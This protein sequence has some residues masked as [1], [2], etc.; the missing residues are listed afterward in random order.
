MRTEL[1]RGL[2]AIDV[3]GHPVKMTMRG[4]QS[5]PNILARIV[6]LILLGLCILFTV[7]MLIEPVE[8]VVTN[9][10]TKKTYACN[11]RRHLST[12]GVN[13]VNDGQ[14]FLIEDLQYERVNISETEVKNKPMENDNYWYLYPFS[15]YFNVAFRVRDKPVGNNQYPFFSVLFTDLQE[16]KIQHF[17]TVPCTNNMFHPDLQAEAGAMNISNYLCIHEPGDI[18]LRGNMYHEQLANF[19]ILL[20]DCLGSSCIDNPTY[21]DGAIVDLV[22]TQGYYSR[23]GNPPAKFRFIQEQIYIE[24]HQKIDKSFNVRWNVIGSI[25][26]IS[27]NQTFYSLT[28]K[29]EYYRT[30]DS[31]QRVEI[32]FE[33][34]SKYRSYGEEEVT[35]MSNS[36]SRNLET[37]FDEESN[38]KTSKKKM[39]VIYEIFYII[40][41]IGGLIN[42]LFL[43]FSIITKGIFDRYFTFQALNLSFDS[44]QKAKTKEP[45]KQSAKQPIQQE[46]PVIQDQ[47]EI[48]PTPEGR[49]PNSEGQLNNGGLGI[50]GFAQILAQME[51]P[52]QNIPKEDE[53]QTPLSRSREK[54]SSKVHPEL[55]KS[56]AKPYSS[57][58][59]IR[60]KIQDFWYSFRCCKK[61]S[62]DRFLWTRFLNFQLYQ[63]ILKKDRDIVKI[64]SKLEIFEMRIAKAET[65]LNTLIHD[66]VV[67]EEEKRISP[68]TEQSKEIILKKQE[69]EEVKKMIEQERLSIMGASK[70]QSNINEDEEFLA[71]K[72]L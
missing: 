18:Y 72:I 21:Y 49:E 46:G 3:F 61:K 10:V 58:E 67:N 29:E 37:I 25:H 33:L 40:S 7:L 41:N 56:N 26:N 45:K 30:S 27:R 59:R 51:G 16:N 42:I 32:R 13:D 38:T 20:R 65:K 35:K 5:L 63:Q 54:K 34:D 53:Q 48:D 15:N 22:Y 11:T 9:T 47:D 50:G 28:S 52:Q 1:Y 69:L 36:F 31:G 60:Y 70:V 24:K 8:D 2:R 68:I 4:N 19:Y 71:V 43:G 64:L 6:I 57:K 17:G 66:I 55:S 14:E 23:F 62:K 44:I 39:N 12:S